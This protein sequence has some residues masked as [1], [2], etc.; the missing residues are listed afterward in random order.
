VHALSSRSAVRKTTSEN[1]RSDINKS[2]ISCIVRGSTVD[3]TTANPERELRAI[4]GR[5][6]CEIIKVYK[7]H[8]I[9]GA[10][11]RDQRPAFN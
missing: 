1:R 11:G 9:R 4:A 2:G 5:M 3:Q 10:K 7:D 6:G 8:G